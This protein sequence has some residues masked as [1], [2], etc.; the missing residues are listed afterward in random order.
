MFGPLVVKPAKSKGAKTGSWRMTVRPH[1][2]H[3]NCIA[4]NL[5]AQICPE[6][7]ISGKEKNSYLPDY[8]YCKGCGL[9]ALVC[10]KADIEMVPE[11]C[12]EEKK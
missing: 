5:C 3:K 1:Y 2:L 10:P 6:H 11:T 7:C 12:E 8:E 4:C 9:C